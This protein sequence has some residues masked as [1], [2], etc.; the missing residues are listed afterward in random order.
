MGVAVREMPNVRFGIHSSVLP[1]IQ[2]CVIYRPNLPNPV[3]PQG[4]WTP[5]LECTFKKY[6][7]TSYLRLLIHH[8]TTGNSKKKKSSCSAQLK[9]FKEFHA[10]EMLKWYHIHLNIHIK[11]LPIRK[12]TWSSG[13]MQWGRGFSPWPAYEL[14]CWATLALSRQGLCRFRRWSTTSQEPLSH[15]I[16]DRWRACAWVRLELFG[17]CSIGISLAE[18]LWRTRMRCLFALVVQLPRT[19]TTSITSLSLESSHQQFCGTPSTNSSKVS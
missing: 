11:V 2:E 13:N 9:W 15:W 6:V 8:I 10:L 7:S 16:S 12:I 19:S 4:A 18:I 14:L 5:N 17:L 1:S 3:L